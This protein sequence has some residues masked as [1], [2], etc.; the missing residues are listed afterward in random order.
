[1]EKSKRLIRILILTLVFSMVCVVYLGKLFSVQLAGKGLY[2]DS[3]ITTRLVT[4]QAARGEIYDRNGKPLVTNSYFYDMTVTYTGFSRLSVFQAN[5]T[6]LLLLGALDA[7]GKTDTHTESYF[8]FAGEYPYYTLTDEAG[9]PD[10]VVG[11]RLRRVLKENGLQED[12]S[13]EEIRKYYVDTYQLLVRDKSGK[14]LFRDDEVDRLFRLRYDMDAV[15]FGPYSDYTL[16]KNVGLDLMTYVREGKNADCVSFTVTAERNY[17]YPGIASH[18][19]GTVGKI[20]SEEWAYYNELGYPMNAVVGKTGC[21][22]AFESDLHGVD[23]QLK[24]TENAVGEVLAIET[25]KEPVAGRNVYLTLDIDLQIAAEEGLAETVQYV[26]EFGEGQ[27]A[28]SF[29]DSGAAV[30]MDPETFEILAIA[31]YPT[32]DLSTYNLDYNDLVADSAKPLLNRALQGV[33][34]PGSTVKPGVAVA[35]LE[36]GKITPTTKLTCTGTYH[37][38]EV[39]GRDPEC[40][41]YY[42]NTHSASAI[43][44]REAIAVSCNSFF[45]ELGYR[46][47]IDRLESYLQRFGFGEPTGIELGEKTGTLAG[48]NYRHAS[49]GLDEM[50]RAAIGQ[51]DTQATPLQLCSYLC[52]LYG[53]GTRQNAHLKDRVTVFGTGEVLWN[54][55]ENSEILSTVEFSDSTYQTVLDGMRDMIVKTSFARTRLSNLGLDDI[56]G[57]TGTPQVEGQNDN[58]MF[59]CGAAYQGQKIAISV[60]TEKSMHGFYNVIAA[61]KILSAWKTTLEKEAGA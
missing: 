16:A 13:G 44:V 54:D 19:L 56:L 30:V 9:D 52:T 45:Y 29:C 31:S 53:G 8:P 47:R 27:T 60:V 49:Y 43:D 46:L 15:R 5:D 42:E 17:H 36:E 10:S 28:A 51:S 4:V 25:V 57:K 6:L 37:N 33:Y 48:E 35:G 3:G 59:L 39:P 55:T 22:L 24:I 58:G 38:P 21:E 18:I 20:W 26:Q 7:C 11:Y 23:G 61:E 40:S 14:R 32:Y 41:T 34:T 50:V 12:L 2:G 1:M